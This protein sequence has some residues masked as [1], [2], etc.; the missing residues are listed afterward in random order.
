MKKFKIFDSATKTKKVFNP[1]SEKEINMYVCGMTVYANCHIGHA[2]LMLFFDTVANIFSHFGYKVNY[3]RNITD[4]DDKIINKANLENI[5]WQE[6]TAKVIQNLNS[7]NKFLNI[8]TPTFEPKATENI[9]EII[10][11]IKILI[12]KKHAYIAN[13]NDVYFS[14]KSFKEY[15]MLSKQ[16]LEATNANTRK[17][18]SK[19]KRDDLDFIL[20]KQAKPNEPFWESPWG[21]GRPGWHIEC[22]AM[23]KKY[24]KNKTLDIHGGG[25]DLKFPH[26]ENEKA[27]S[28][29]AFNHSFVNYWMHVGHV[30]VD[31]VKM[32]K[33][34]NNFTTITNLTKQFHSEVIRFFLLSTHYKSPLNYN[35]NSLNNSKKSLLSIYTTLDNNLGHIDE[36]LIHEFESALLDDFNT[37]KAIAVCF[38]LVKNNNATS[39]KKCLNILKLG[40]ATSKEILE[41]NIVR[42]D[43]T[44]IEKLIE[45]RTLAKTNKDWGL[46]DQIRESLEQKNI[47][48]EDTAKGTTWRYQS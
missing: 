22:S 35:N 40:F 19:N 39:L 28:E 41:F 12:D 27:Q 23:A 11:L 24:N 1:I 7:D 29:A 5:T 33:S 42:P 37:P 16:N 2:R 17:T 14:A 21:N 46:A 30:T 36:K 44:E 26:H 13:D 47:I 3:I 45:Q 31:S 18:L 10:E 48:L 6:L 9:K 34:L 8:Q 4:I 38:K 43:K 32:S 25:I 15:G 20:W